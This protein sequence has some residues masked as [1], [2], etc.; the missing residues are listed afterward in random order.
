MIC[1]QWMIYQNDSLPETHYVH[2]Q[3]ILILEVCLREEWITA[4]RN[5][6]YKKIDHLKSKVG[7]VIDD[8]GRKKYQRFL[9]VWPPSP[10]LSEH[11]HPFWVP[12][13]F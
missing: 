6:H 11:P 2:S 5:S 12:P 9:Q 13:S 7:E 8:N 10:F 4:K 3:P 1:N